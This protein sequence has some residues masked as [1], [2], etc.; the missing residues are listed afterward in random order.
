[1]I[2]KA[3]TLIELLIVVAIIAIL[4]AIAVP[5]FLEAQT[6]AKV[7]RVVADMRTVATAIESYKIDTNKYPFDFAGD[8]WYA[9]YL[10]QGLTTPISYLPNARLEDVFAKSQ[11]GANQGVLRRF[12]Y[13][14]FSETWLSATHAGIPWG[15]LPGPTAPGNAKARQ[16]HGDWFLASKGPDS[17]T[18]P[19]PAGFADG[20]NV[21]DWLWAL[22]DPSNGT[23]SKGDVLRGQKGDINSRGYDVNVTYT[24]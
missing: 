8:V 20:N 9:Y 19:L 7:A 4:A 24:P 5:N 17:T 23:L 11:S 3:F 13:R 22:Y 14:A 12:R 16:V 6:R 2:R 15:T 1:M 21:N 18:G 10:N